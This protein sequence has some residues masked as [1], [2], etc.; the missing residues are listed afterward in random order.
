MGKRANGR[1]QWLQGGISSETHFVKC[2]GRSNGMMYQSPV[3][4]A[5]LIT[6]PCKGFLSSLFHSHCPLLPPCDQ[7]PDKLPA[8]TLCFRLC[9]GNHFHDSTVSIGLL[10]FSHQKTIR[11]RILTYSFLH[12][13]GL[14]HS[15]TLLY[16]LKNK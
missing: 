16:F 9:F 14:A 2:L 4:G 10:F 5:N 13:P 1:S 8:H 12:L 3:V 6:H 11:I 7:F 15:K